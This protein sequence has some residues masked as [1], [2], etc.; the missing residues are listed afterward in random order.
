MDTVI[1]RDLA[2]SF[3]I[4]VTDAER[5]KPQRLLLT[6]E[7][8]SDFTG[9]ARLDDLRQTIDYYAVCQRLL[10][11]GEGRSW[12]LIETLAVNIADLV[13]S[14]FGAATVAVEVKKFIIP[15]TEYVS[16]RIVRP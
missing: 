15:E 2:V 9:A 11:L 8:G 10:H 1:I 16:V 4:G 5:A 12:K 6:I 14:E 13:R 3:C 7:M